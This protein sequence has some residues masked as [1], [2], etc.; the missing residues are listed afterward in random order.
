MPR[1]YPPEFR[2]RVLD[3]IASGRKVSD[4]ARDLGV[5]GQTIY[6][7]RA[8]DLIDRGERPGLRSSELAELAA[9]RRRIAQLE[10]ELAATRRAQELLKGAVPPKGASR[11]SR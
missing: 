3:L 5:S 8:Q 11:P 1:G 9:A 10:A 4:V 6:N 7:W 2:R